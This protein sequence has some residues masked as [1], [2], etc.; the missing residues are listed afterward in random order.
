MIGLADKIRQIELSDFR[1]YT[2]DH[3]F[4]NLDADI[5]LLTGK[6]GAGKT[7]LLQAITLGLNGYDNTVFNDIDLI[8]LVS[9][10]KEYRIAMN[11]SDQRKDVKYWESYRTTD[12][13]NPQ[14][15]RASTCYFQEWAKEI[16]KDEFK[17]FNRS[18]Q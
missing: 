3:T 6:N 16:A 5:V 17:L 13:L 18:K 10:K 11:G 15:L 1:G 8:N 12:L 2:N 4:K 7:S 9:G 14:V